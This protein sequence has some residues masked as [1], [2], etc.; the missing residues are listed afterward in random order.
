[1]ILIMI[2][3]LFLLSL[4]PVETI[5]L[6]K[7]LN[8]IVMYNN[9][10]YC[11]PRIGMSIFELTKAR[12]LRPIS[13][14][15]NLNYRIFDFS[16]TPF[17]IYLNNG[18]SIDKFYFASGTKETIYSARNIS[19]F[20]LT[21]SLEIVCADD[22]MRELVFLDFT[23]RV[24][25]KEPDVTVK[26]LQFVDG[27]ICA[28]TKKNIIRFDEHGNVLEK[29]V[30]PE[31]LNNIFIDSTNTFLFSPEKNYV[32]IYKD[33][34]EKIDFPYSITDI[35]GNN[36]LIVILDGSSSRLFFYNKSNF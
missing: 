30:I 34:W 31:R 13:F 1:M 19:S 12:K 27:T 26:D 2:P 23:N 15:D 7:E 33:S 35:S 18:R 16:M 5:D 8:S 9:T 17:A 36:Q 29:I 32:Y 22:E 3:L 28:L 4:E 24:K 25:Y 6:D 14:T 11:A 20:T 21:S 10:V